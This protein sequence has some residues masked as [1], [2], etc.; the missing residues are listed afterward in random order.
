MPV[1]CGGILVNPGDIVLADDDGVVVLPPAR[2]AEIVAICLPR[3]QQGR[4]RQQRMREGTP[5]GE[6]SG[7]HARID[8]M[9]QRQ[10]SS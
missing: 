7:A 8:E 1:R 2:I 5:L 9:L 6:L 3:E 10:S 4:E